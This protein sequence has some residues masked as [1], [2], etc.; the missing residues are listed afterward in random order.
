[1]Y[2]T[3]SHKTQTH[4]P[5]RELDWAVA[6]LQERPTLQI[7]QTVQQPTNKVWE[8]FY[9]DQNGLPKKYKHSNIFLPSTVT[10]VKKHKKWIKKFRRHYLELWTKN[11]EHRAVLREHEM[12]QPWHCYWRLRRSFSDLGERFIVDLVLI[13]QIHPSLFSVRIVRLQIFY[14][15]Q[16]LSLNNT[17]YDD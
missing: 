10:F 15:N 11:D 9:K 5:F 13:H 12:K 16:S 8:Y 1:M 14:I 2:V 17:W 6:F 7:F 3:H 4:F